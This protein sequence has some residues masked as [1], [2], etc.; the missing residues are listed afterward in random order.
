M[1]SN[2]LLYMPPHQCFCYPGVKLSGFN[3]LTSKRES[4]IESPMSKVRMVECGPAYGQIENQESKTENPHNWPTFRHDAK[5][6]GSAASAVSADVKRLWQA[7]LGDRITQPVVADGKLF[8][9]SI[10]EHSISCLN[11]EDG[12]LL[13]S[14]TAG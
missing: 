7:D 12:E 14:Y 10:D 1:P 6:S 8:I 9:A 5:R 11:A 4:K 2:G 13:W 3:A